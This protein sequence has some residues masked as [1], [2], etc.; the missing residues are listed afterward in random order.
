[1]NKKGALNLTKYEAKYIEKKQNRGKKEKQKKKKEKKH[2]FFKK[3]DKNRN[4]K[5]NKDQTF[6]QDGL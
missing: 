5:E 4:G 3:M 2:N 1:M 6:V